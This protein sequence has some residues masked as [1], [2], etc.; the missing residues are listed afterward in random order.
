MSNE[1]VLVLKLPMLPPPAGRMSLLGRFRTLMS[2]LWLDHA[3]FRY[4]YNTRHRIA[5][6]VYRS[7]HPMPSQLRAAAEVGIRTIINLRGVDPN[8]A[9]N[10]LSW[11]ACERYGLKLVHFPLYSRQAPTREEVLG[12]NE[13]FKKVERPFLLHCKSGADRAGLASVLYLLLQDQQPLE[14][15]LRQL[16]L[17]PYGH[18]RQ[19]KAGILDHFFECYRQHRDRHGTS[20]EDWVSNHYR[21]KIV[22]ASFH[23]IWWV[24]KLTD[25]LLRRE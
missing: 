20:F 13:L 10:R 11:E 8:I 15:A 21:P 4:F 18:I 5:D 14:V 22:T 9:S 23:D 17:W 1:A 16:R 25:W 6:G 19:A 24:T 7:S 12:L 3:I 2:T